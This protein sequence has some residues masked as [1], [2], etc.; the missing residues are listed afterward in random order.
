MLNSTLKAYEDIL[1]QCK[2]NQNQSMHLICLQTKTL[3]MLYNCIQTIVYLKS[4]E[5]DNVLLD[6]WRACHYILFSPTFVSNFEN[7]VTF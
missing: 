7:F 4:L 2:W 1:K 6:K 5:Y 3:Y